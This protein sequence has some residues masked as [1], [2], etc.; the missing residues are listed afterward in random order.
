MK[1]VAK[2]VE[3]ASRSEVPVDS[4]RERYLHALTLVERLHHR[5]LDVIK[6]ELD[7]HGRRDITSIQALMIYSIG[8]QEI[9]IGELRT[10]GYYLG[11][12][13]T[14]NLKKLVGAGLVAHQRSAIDRRSAHIKLTDKGRQVHDIVEALCLRHAGTVELAGGIYT[15]DLATANKLLQR[16]ERFWIDQ[17]VYRL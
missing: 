17:V 16:L 9:C 15:D 1:V 7:R 11:T 2:A 8:E 14:Y 6:D 13:V 12:N 10:R 4:I 3:S 5:W